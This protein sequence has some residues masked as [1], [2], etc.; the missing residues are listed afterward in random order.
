MGVAVGALKG[1]GKTETV[2]PRCLSD[3]QEVS[4]ACTCSLGVEGGAVPAAR[5][6]KCPRC[7]RDLD[8]LNPAGDGRWKGSSDTVT[9]SAL[10]ERAGL[11]GYQGRS[12]QGWSEK[13]GWLR[14]SLWP[15]PSSPLLSDLHRS[16]RAV[17]TRLG[18]ILDGISTLV[19][20]PR[21]SQQSFCFL[22]SLFREISS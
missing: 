22:T 13:R 10:W 20:I 8:G 19:N 11:P 21:V 14:A 5:S 16:N 17:V 4:L 12:G 18:Q 9:G 6:G 3:L 7:Q 1:L 2:N 15:L